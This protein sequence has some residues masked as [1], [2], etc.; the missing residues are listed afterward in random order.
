MT[1]GS[2]QM[3]FKLNTRNTNLY[4]R[5]VMTIALIQTVKIVITKENIKN[6]KINYIIF[7]NYH[8]KSM[9]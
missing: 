7:Y 3:N 4:Q 6:I 1:V 8:T 2:G 9:N 5:D